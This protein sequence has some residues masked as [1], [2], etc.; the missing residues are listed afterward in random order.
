MELITLLVL[1]L[2]AAGIVGSIIPMMP[3]ALFSITG[4]LIYFFGAEDPSIWFTAFGLLTSVFTLT[5]D[6]FAGSIAAKYG[7][8][9]TKTSLA[10]GV[11]GLLGFIFLGGPVGLA[12]AVSATVFIREYLIHGDEREGLQAAFYATI[13]VLGSAVIQAMLTGSILIAFILALVI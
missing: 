11:T 13:G 3:G 5:V 8:A 4:V 9:S 10:A 2:L 12:L 1:A 7:G 6:W